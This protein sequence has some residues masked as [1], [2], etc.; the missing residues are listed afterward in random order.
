LALP[1]VVQ[2]VS[3]RAAGQ[4]A[5]LKVVSSEQRDDELVTLATGK[6]PASLVDGFGADGK[7]SMLVETQAEKV[8]TAIRIG[9]T[10][11]AQSLPRLAG[12]CSAV[13]PQQRAD[14]SAVTADAA[15]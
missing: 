2:S 3:L 7:H 12:A 9:N 13:A 14:A 1:K 6:I 8:R 11:V 10:G 5:A 4:E 15:K